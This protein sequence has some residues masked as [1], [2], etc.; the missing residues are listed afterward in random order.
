MRPAAL[1]LPCSR[2]PDEEIRIAYEPPLPVQAKVVTLDSDDD[3]GPEDVPVMNRDGTPARKDSRRLL[4][5]KHEAFLVAD[6]LPPL[7]PKHAYRR[8]PVRSPSA[9]ERC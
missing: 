8:T 3:S 1:F 4:I 2:P 9:K 5:Q 6:Y 7:P